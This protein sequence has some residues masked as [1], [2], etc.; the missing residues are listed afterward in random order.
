MKLKAKLISAII[1]V[2]LASI[3]SVKVSGEERPLAFA[4]AEG[5]GK[6]TV[7]GRG[8]KVYEVTNLNDSGPGSLREAVNKKGAR[9]IVFRVSGTI[10]LKSRLRI[11]NPYITIAGQTAPGDGITLKGYPLELFA[12]EIIIRYIRVRPGGQN[13]EFD[14]IFGRYQNNII[15][16]HVSASWSVD[17][18]MSIYHNTNVT[19]QWCLISESL[20]GSVH[21]KGSHGFGGIWGN[22]YGSYH[23]NLFAHHSSRTPRWASG[24]G[25][26]DYRNNVCYNWGYN[27]MYGG[28]AALEEPERNSFFLNMVNNY[29]KAGP[30]SRY[31]RQL[32][33][34]DGNDIAEGVTRQGIGRYFLEG[35]ILEGNEEVNADNWKGVMIKNSNFSLADARLDNPWESMPVS[36][37][38]AADAFVSVLD[39]AG[40][41][42]PRRDEV[43]TRI[44]AEALAGTATYEGETYKKNQTWA[45]QR[46]KT[47]MIDS[48]EDVGGWPELLSSV[49]PVDSDH[50]G[51]PDVWEIRNGL[52]ANNPDD[53]NIIDAEG[54]TNLDKYLDAILTEGLDS[55]IES[56][57]IESSNNAN[58]RYY[59]L[60]GLLSS[61]PWKR[62]SI[63]VTDDIN[64][65]HKTE[66]CIVR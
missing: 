64:R 19:I 36:E 25:H 39:N 18:T 1:A 17:E 47:G 57:E 32:V 11:S 10:E 4:T 23:H 8:G 42:F 29:Y 16:D 62:F 59:N 7:G 12:N 9:V 65:K 21:A 14:A 56:V 63:K 49:A 35:N 54:Y 30:G 15:L 44:V 3:N 38:S 20:Y 55:G 13:G 46:G 61:S 51:I 31:N 45:A 50:D 5:Y 37:Q 34:A 60:S 6:Y 22:D 24:S 2:S 33:Q 27:N 43:D 52:D 53:A 40:C 66:K 28:E 26:N 41:S 58:V 48:P